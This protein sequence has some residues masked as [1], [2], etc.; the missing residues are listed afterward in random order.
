[1]WHCAALFRMSAKKKMPDMR[2]FFVDSNSDEKA[3]SKREKTVSGVNEGAILAW[4]KAAK[5]AHQKK[6]GNGKK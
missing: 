4:L 1:M 2:M 3:A 5:A 6:T